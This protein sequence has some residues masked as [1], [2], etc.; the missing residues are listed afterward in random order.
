MKTDPTITNA[1]TPIAEPECVEQLRQLLRPGSQLDAEIA[2]LTRELETAL[3]DENLSKSTDAAELSMRVL[4]PQLELGV[5]ERRRKIAYSQARALLPQLV[6]A[7]EGLSERV[8]TLHDASMRLVKKA[9]IERLATVGHLFDET[10][11]ESFT[12]RAIPIM[13]QHAFRAE[14]PASFAASYVLGKLPNGELGP[15]LDPETNPHGLLGAWD[16]LRGSHAAVAGRLERLM[17]TKGLLP[18]ESTPTT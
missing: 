6:T 13:R 9:V 12:R 15:V 8:A 11:F 5:L 4:R 7:C 2:K 17:Q 14:H 1:A 10:T 18:E 3:A 16:R